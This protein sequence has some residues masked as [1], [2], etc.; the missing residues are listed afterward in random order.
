MLSLSEKQIPISNKFAFGYGSK[1]APGGAGL[2]QLTAGVWQHV[3]V[4]CDGKEVVIC[5]DGKEATRG[6]C[7]N[8][9]TP[10]PQLGFRLASGYA[11]GRFF[12]GAL[13]DFRIYARALSAEEI[14]AL[15]QDAGNTG[16]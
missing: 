6:T 15:A 12:A 16:K 7:L 2:V 10:H 8:P 13:D 9:L 5:V 14:V 11:E 3:A 4:V 1:P